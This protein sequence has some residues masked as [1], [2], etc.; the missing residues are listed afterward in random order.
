MKREIHDDMKRLYWLAGLSVVIDL[1]LIIVNLV[2]DG[3]CFTSSG[4][5]DPYLLIAGLVLF[6]N[7]AT[8]TYSLWFIVHVA[9]PG[10]FQEYG[11]AFVEGHY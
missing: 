1:V 9:N 2:K 5:F 6:L 10:F 3:R 8:L 4:T 11:F 7:I